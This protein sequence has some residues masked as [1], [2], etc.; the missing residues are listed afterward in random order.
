MGQIYTDSA[1]KLNC[2]YRFNCG[3]KQCPD[4]VDFSKKPPCYTEK[5]KRYQP[6]GKKVLH[7]R[8]WEDIKQITWME[9]FTFQESWIYALII[10]IVSAFLLMSM[11]LIKIMVFV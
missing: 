5:F 7:R 2:S 6:E 11:I 1:H 8:D 4:S 9:V 3:T 10:I